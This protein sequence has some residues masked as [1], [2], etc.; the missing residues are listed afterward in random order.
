MEGSE[1]FTSIPELKLGRVTEFPFRALE[2][3]IAFPQINLEGAEGDTSERDECFRS[4]KEVQLAVEV[5]ATRFV[6][7]GIGFI[8]GRC[9]A[10]GAGD[11]RAG[12]AESIAPVIT[13]RLVCHSRFKERTVE[14][15]ATAVPGKDSARSIC[16]VGGRGEADDCEFCRRITESWNRPAPVGF[17]GVRLPLLP[18]DRFAVSPESRAEF[19]AFNRA[20]KCREIWGGA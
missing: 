10:N 3:E 11:P 4:G 17:G 20:G 12:Q 1:N 14:P 18:C 19:A 6:F 15:F 5:G 13:L 8:I 9:A 7:I 16:A 2:N